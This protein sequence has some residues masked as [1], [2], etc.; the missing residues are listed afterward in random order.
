MQ[1]GELAEANEG[2]R[3]FLCARTAWI[4]AGAMKGMGG[5][6]KGGRGE[7]G[8]RWGRGPMGGARGEGMGRAPV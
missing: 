3:A 6:E 5:E 8:A 7:K 2:E 4:Q 1:H